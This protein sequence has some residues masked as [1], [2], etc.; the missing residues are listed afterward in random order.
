MNR[1]KLFQSC[2]QISVKNPNN[3]GLKKVCSIDIQ[4]RILKQKFL[5]NE[6]I[7]G[8]GFAQFNEQG[9]IATEVF[10]LKDDTEAAESMLF[11]QFDEFLGKANPM[12]VSGFHL[13]AYDIPLLA[14]KRSHH[15]TSS[16]G[17]WNIGNLVEYSLLLELK[18]QTRFAVFEQT[19]DFKMRT[20]E[21][22]VQLAFFKDLSLQP[23]VI[24]EEELKKEDFIY[25][26]WK[27]ENLKFDNLLRNSVYNNL[28]FTKKLAETPN[29]N[30]SLSN[31]SGTPLNPQQQ[32]PKKTYPY[33]KS[34]YQNTYQAPQYQKKTWQKNSPASSSNV[35]SSNPASN[36]SPNFQK[37]SAPT[38][39]TTQVDDFPPFNIIQNVGSNSSTNSSTNGNPKVDK[40]K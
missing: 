9:Q 32:Y 19:N 29:L 23:S 38:P 39:N 24:S 22:L 35:G 16:T 7:L 5:S 36:F 28:L 17:F 18:H 12:I 33:T 10:K 27:S 31:A 20:P 8:I 37:N 34:T 21:Q 25:E 40:K 6:R 11:S 15:R 2:L 26:L 14:I 30:Q 3:N 4:S 13:T 1:F